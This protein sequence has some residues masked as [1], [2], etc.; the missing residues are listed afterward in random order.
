MTSSSSISR[1]NMIWTTKDTIGDIDEFE[2]LEAFLQ[3]DE[4]I[5]WKHPDIVQQAQ[6][7]AMAATL[8]LANNNNN[9][10]NPRLSKQE[11]LERNVI[12]TCYEWVRDEVV[13]SVDGKC[14]PPMTCK[15]SDVLKHNTGFSFAKSH[16]LTALLRANDIPAGLCYQRLTLDGVE[17]DVVDEETT[18]YCLHGLNAVL[19]SDGT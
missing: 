11:E 9:I 13:H 4:I 17:V 3:S 10:K 2:L 5:D 19:L 14:G 18:Q 16:L 6:L 15:A 1:S 8:T 12:S 7:L